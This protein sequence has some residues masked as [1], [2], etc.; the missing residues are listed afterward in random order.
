MPK[1]IIYPGDFPIGLMRWAP[2]ELVAGGRY[3]SNLGLIDTIID[4]TGGQVVIPPSPAGDT[5]PWCWQVLGATGRKVAVPYLAD[6]IA[7]DYV[8][9]PTVSDGISCIPDTK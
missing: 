3:G 2:S 1:I 8:T 4:S 9:L 6:D 7:V 5:P